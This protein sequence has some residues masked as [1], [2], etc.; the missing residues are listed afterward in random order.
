MIESRRRS[1]TVPLGLAFFLALALFIG[2]SV[3][4]YEGTFD[5]AVDVDVVL[6]SAGNAL[7]LR[8]DVKVRGVMV[9]HVDSTSVRDGPVVA[10]LK[11]MPSYASYISRD[12][13][14]RL[15]P[16]TLFGERYVAL[17]VPEGP[18]QPIV[19][20][21]VLM[22]DLS[23]NAIEV[24][25][26]LDGLAPLLQA[27]PPQDLANTLGALAQGLSGRGER[28]GTTIDRLE[29]IFSQVNAEMP[30]LQE[31]IRGV[32][33]LADTYSDALPS[34]V[35]ALD[36]FRVTGNTVVERRP[37]VDTLIAS[38]TSSATTTADFVAAN[39][40]DIISLA[41]DSRYLLETLDQYTP[42]VKCF[43]DQIVAVVPQIPEVLDTEN[44]FPGIQGTAEFINTK[45]RF[46]PNQDEPRFLDDRPPR[47]LPSAP[48][49]EN[50]P[51]YSG[52]SFNDGA[53][54]VPSR[55]PGPQ[56]DDATTTDNRPFPATPAS[57][58]G[59][60]FERSTLAVVYANRGGVAPEDIPSWTTALGAPAMRG[61]QVELR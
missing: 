58:A 10:H 45:G 33:D 32:A 59:S 36:N 35:D 3:T 61:N 5:A 37:A 14:A 15:L 48:P 56:G 51:Q 30:A 31:D 54:Q 53:Y 24:G 29:N 52:G 34:L 26:L 55:N 46:L 42:T 1:T 6:D 17:M 40:N 38:L 11:I 47:C 49:G 16:K 13:T 9:G 60:D 25:E 20:G 50:T 7:P 4:R 23:G 41:D 8:A 44:E 2:W 22:Q 27:I 12:A 57:Y 28:I 21:S 43:L 18:V 19:D 39:S